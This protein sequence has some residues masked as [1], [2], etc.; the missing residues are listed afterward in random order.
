MSSMNHGA[1]ADV[2]V[3]LEMDNCPRKH[4]KHATFLN[5]GPLFKDNL[6]PISTKDSARANVTVRSHGDMSD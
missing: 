3:L 2:G 4:V 5:V 1:M 6:S